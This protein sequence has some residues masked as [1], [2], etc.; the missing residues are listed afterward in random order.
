MVYWIGTRDAETLA[1]AVERYKTDCGAYPPASQGF[2]GLVLDYGVKGWR[3]SYLKGLPVD[4]WRRPYIYL[5][6]SGTP[7]IL[8]YGADGKP[9]G[10]FFD[11]DISSRNLRWLMPESPYEFRARVSFIRM[12]LAAWFCFIGSILGLRK[13]WRFP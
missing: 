10:E 9:G 11:A 2:S 4:P 3:G 1:K 12:W 13:V 5:L 6:T 7:E 8:S